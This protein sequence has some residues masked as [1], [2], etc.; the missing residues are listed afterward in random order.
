MDE[1]ETDEDRIYNLFN[2]LAE[3]EQNIEDIKRELRELGVK[4]WQM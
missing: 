1:E 2:E 3:A 4:E